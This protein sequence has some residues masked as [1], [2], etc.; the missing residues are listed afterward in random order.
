MEG[1]GTDASPK[2]IRDT[3]SSK[4]LDFKKK[5]MGDMTYSDAS[6]GGQ[7]VDSFKELDFT[8]W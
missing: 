6:E 4:I 7:L 3:L 8:C 5:L 1:G 2:L